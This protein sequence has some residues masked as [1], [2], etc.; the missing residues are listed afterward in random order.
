MPLLTLIDYNI[1]VKN[2]SLPVINVATKDNPSYL[3]AEV[4]VVMPGQP[5]GTKLS[6]AQT[7]QMIRF[8][9]RRPHQ[10]FQSV[11]SSGKNLLGLEKGNSTMDSFGLE[12]MPKMITV[13]GRVLA[14][15]VVKYS[16][17]STVMPR[18]GSWNMQSVK[19]VTKS[20]LPSWSFLRI[21]C[22]RNPFR[23]PD[24]F[25]G[26]ISEF[27][28][29]LRMLGMDVK[30]FVPGQHI[31]PG[32]GEVVGKIDE[33]IR[34]FATAPNP[35]KLILVIVPEDN[36]TEVYNR[37]KLACDVTYGILNVC[38]LDTKFARANPQY[39]ANVGLKFNL[40][41]G[42]RNHSVEPAKLGFISQKKTM[43]VGLDV[44]HPSPGSASTAPSVASIVASVDEWLQQW[45]AELR[46]QDARTEVVE[47]LKAMVKSRLLL[48]KS[49]NQN[50]LPENILVYR[51]G[52]SEGQYNIVV[53]EE[54]KSLK[55]ACKEV[56]PATD[57][58]ARKPKI[59]IIIVGKRHNTRFYVTR[60]EDADRGGN[61]S[62]GTVV[63]RG[64]TEARNWDFFLQAHS[65]IQGTA[66]PAHY[67]VVYD[68][69]FRDMK[70]T[71]QFPTAADALEDL[72]HN[73][74]YLF[75]R[76]T[77]AVSI[78]PPAYYADLVCTRARCYLSKLFDPGFVSDT[79]SIGTD[80]SGSK[81]DKSV[82]RIHPN[83]QNSMFY[84]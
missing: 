81:P 70:L 51:D 71:P 57:I 55:E 62:N 36:K 42:G 65:A 82:V 43:I 84:I 39:H 50:M 49:R 66:R 77:K 18:F 23:N 52:V 3:P 80:S 19:F 13:P 1:T 10:N 73:M 7:Q 60:K 9:V 2:L 56:Y 76:A 25:H 67:Y 15:P 83:V 8:A 14:A 16:G 20:S 6:G 45:P 78:C 22:G 31:T 4:C 21:A 59:T 5:A 29:Q 30:N 72:T 34:K 32:P 37:V 40:K 46:I 33:A 17:S 79:S 48:W 69:I 12:V 28:A 11:I 41:L 35:P 27:Q 63:D 44:T 38:V 75:G 47:D 68:E 24:E 58:K 26:K 61:P 64:V 53:N 74:C 54:L